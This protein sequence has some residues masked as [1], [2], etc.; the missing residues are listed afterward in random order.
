M[1]ITDATHYIMI[2]GPYEIADDVP[3]WTVSVC[4]DDGEPVDHG[5][6]RLV[7]Y[8]TEHAAYAAAERLADTFDLEIV[9]T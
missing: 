1:N 6:G 3:E 7:G 4:D 2:D 9:D 5:P 8:S